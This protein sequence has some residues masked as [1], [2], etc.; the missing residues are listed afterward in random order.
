MIP[1][2]GSTAEPGHRPCEPYSIKTLTR[3]CTPV[4][5]SPF[6]PGWEEA[7]GAGCKERLWAPR[8]RRAWALCVPTPS[9]EGWRPALPPA[10]WRSHPP[11]KEPAAFLSTASRSENTARRF[12]SLGPREALSCLHACAHAVPFA[13]M[14]FPLFPCLSESVTEWVLLRPFPVPWGKVSLR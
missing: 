8:G 1:T 6:H 10:P 3:R 4:S 11:F 9:G 13:G 2:S 7:G 12:S 5:R 14:P